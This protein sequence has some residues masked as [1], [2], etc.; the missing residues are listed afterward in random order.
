MDLGLLYR[1]MKNADIARSPSQICKLTNCTSLLAMRC[2]F[3]VF[4]TNSK[5][6]RRKQELGWAYGYFITTRKI[7]DKE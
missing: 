7:G 6:C 2:I 1:N 4:M 5:S 3:N